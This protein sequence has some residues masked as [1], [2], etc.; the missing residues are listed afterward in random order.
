MQ[1]DH[2]VTET[3]GA[4]AWIRL[5]QP[6]AMNA[7]STGLVRDLGVAV[8]NIRCDDA[9]RAVVLTG[10]GRAFCAGADLK[11]VLAG[12]DQPSSADG[13][14]LDAIAVVFKA[15]RDLPKPVIGGLNGLT[16]A[17][18]LELAMCCDVLIATESAK[19]GDAHS[20]FGVFPGAGGAAIMPHRSGA[21]NAKYF[22]FSGQN[23]PAREWLRLGLVQEVVADDGF[24]ARL[25]EFST[26]LAQKSPL[27]LA[28]MKQTVAATADMPQDDALAYEL[29]VLR[30][31]LKSNDLAEGLA[32]FSEK[33]TPNFTGT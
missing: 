32:A 5:N 7:L 29:A 20:N 22:L 21:A 24:E 8:E 30:E 1:F 17:G 13:D 19:I 25:A 6:D 26:M 9:V 4:V 3:H 15:L 2:I 12:L 14:F 18:G 33:R 31:H 16:L 11:E 10:V 27:V 28:R 23:M